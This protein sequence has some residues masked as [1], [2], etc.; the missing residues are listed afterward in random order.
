ME[1][2]EVCLLIV[3]ISIVIIIIIINLKYFKTSFFVIE[4][5]LNIPFHEYYDLLLY[6]CSW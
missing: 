3:Y 1:L 5:E 6:Y 2:L 4:L